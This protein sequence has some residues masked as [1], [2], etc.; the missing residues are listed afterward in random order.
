[1]TKNQN[2]D[3]FMA[4]SRLYHIAGNIAFAPIIFYLFRVWPW[5]PTLVHLGVFV[6]TS[7]IAFR[8]FKSR[9]SATRLAIGTIGIQEDR[10]IPADDIAGVKLSGKAL[11]IKLKSDDSEETIHLWWASAGDVIKIDSIAKELFGNYE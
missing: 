9:A 7:I 5:P 6:L 3:F 4:R 10:L 11:K 8:Y 1:M 2:H